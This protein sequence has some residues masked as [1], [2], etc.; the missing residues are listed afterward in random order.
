MKRLSLVTIIFS[1]S[2]GGLAWATL[3]DWYLGA[4][5][6]TRKLTG[7]ERA[8]E[9]NL[10]DQSRNEFLRWLHHV[11]ANDPDDGPLSQT[12]TNGSIP[13]RAT[14]DELIDPLMVPAGE[15]GLDATLPS[16]LPLSRADLQPRALFSHL[17]YLIDESCISDPSTW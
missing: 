9:D 6:S 7:R 15:P 2:V 12:F 14:L 4:S 13:P 11:V 3:S 1:I 10:N 16:T 17:P 5:L 8:P